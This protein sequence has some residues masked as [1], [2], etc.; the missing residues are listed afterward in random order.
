VLKAT[1]AYERAVVRSMSMRAHVFRYP[2]HVS[3]GFA[4]FASIDITLYTACVVWCSE[5]LAADP[6]VPGSI[7]GHARFSE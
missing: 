1:I 4:Q 2:L 6:E 7:P 5:F 3:R